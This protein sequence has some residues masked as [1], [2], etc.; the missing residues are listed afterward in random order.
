MIYY[1]MKRISQKQRLK[2][3]SEMDYQERLGKVENSPRE[4]EIEFFKIITKEERETI[5]KDIQKVLNIQKQRK[6]K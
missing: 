4:E 1:D 6:K 2:P 5:K 3:I